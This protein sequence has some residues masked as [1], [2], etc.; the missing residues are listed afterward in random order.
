MSGPFCWVLERSYHQLQGI[1]TPWRRLGSRSSRASWC[2]D[3]HAASREPCRWPASPRRASRRAWSWS[4]RGRNGDPCRPFARRVGALAV[5]PLRPGGRR[6]G[7][8][9]ALDGDEME[10]LLV[11]RAG[12]LDVLGQPLGDLSRD[13]ERVVDVRLALLISAVLE[14][15]DL[16]GPCHVCAPGGSGVGVTHDCTTFVAT[17]HALYLLVSRDALNSAPGDALAVDP[18]PALVGRDVLDRSGLVV[19]R[20]AVIDGRDGCHGCLVPVL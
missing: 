1:G 19:R 8:G 4:R 6:E 13:G 3:V 5:G 2:R 14:L 17:T 16:I 10:T 20:G 11:H 9:R 12:V 7:L 18:P 15:P